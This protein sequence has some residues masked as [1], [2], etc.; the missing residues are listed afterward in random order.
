MM[1]GMMK[2]G[3]M[4]SSMMKMMHEKGMMSEECMSSCMKMMGDKGMNMNKMDGTNKEGGS[5]H[6]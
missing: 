6:H 3:K 2:D 4:M 5:E 1:Q